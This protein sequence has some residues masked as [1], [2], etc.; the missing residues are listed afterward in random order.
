[1]CRHPRI[2]SQ[3]LICTRRGSWARITEGKAPTGSAEMPL[4]PQRV[5]FAAAPQV[6]W[7]Q[8]ETA[9]SAKTRNFSPRPQK[10]SWYRCCTTRPEH[11]ATHPRGLAD[12]PVEEMPQVGEVLEVVT[13]TAPTPLGFCATV[14]LRDGR[15]VVDAATRALVV[16]RAT[17][18]AVP[19]VPLLA[20]T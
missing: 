11:A 6:D 7:D 14:T 2:A 9:V 19:A 1:M 16:L 15:T 13:T 18:D 5:A 10:T 17:Y 4:C 12:E 8:L 20:V 3:A